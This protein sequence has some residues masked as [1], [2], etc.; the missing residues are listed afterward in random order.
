[1]GHFV[2]FW[3]LPNTPDREAYSAFPDSLSRNCPKRRTSNAPSVDLAGIRRPRWALGWS[4]G[5][6]AAGPFDPFRT[7]SRSME[8]YELRLHRFS[9]VRMSSGRNRGR[10][11]TR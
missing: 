7:V 9:E 6:Y 2:S 5:L 11:T 4:V 10:S 8:F 3:P 1:M